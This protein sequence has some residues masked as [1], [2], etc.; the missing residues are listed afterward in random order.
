MQDKDTIHG[1]FNDRV[2]LVV[3]TWR[4]KHHAHEVARIAQVVP[5]IHVGLADAVFVGHC[6]QSGHLGNE[7][8]GGYVA[9]LWVVDI[10]AV[11]VKRW[12]GTQQA[13]HDGHTRPTTT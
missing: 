11:M 6:H 9:V 8:Q 12:Q 10:S 13:A 4:G 1:A 3:F 2:D 7:S 5:W